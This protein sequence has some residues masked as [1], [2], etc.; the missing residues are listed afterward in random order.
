LV[1]LEWHLL[2]SVV[3]LE[4]APHFLQSLV[5]LKSSQLLDIDFLM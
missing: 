5:V 1:P 2:E 3:G 4:Q